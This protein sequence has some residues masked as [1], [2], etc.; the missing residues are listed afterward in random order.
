[1]VL[2]VLPRVALAGA[3]IAAAAPALAHHAMDGETPTTLAQGFLSGLAHPVIGPDH[4]A[5][6]VGIGI[7]SAFIRRGW[8]LPAIFLLAGALGTALHL[9]GI[10]VPGA[11]LLVALSVLLAGLAIWLH[12]RTP[13]AIAA[14]LCGFGGMVHGYVQA[15]SIVGA[16]PSPLGAYLA[17]LAI[18]QLGI[19]L[20][21]REAT[22]RLVQIRP[23]MATRL[24]MAASAA[25]ALVG[26]AALPLWAG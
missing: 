18:V 11:E 7:L 4:L 24:T 20:G 8:T 16:E 9:G 15:E 26:I 1:M 6:V 19:A 13:L 25:V 14:A 22:R 10:G 21:V 17:G 3:A 5:F 12:G 2:R 23:V